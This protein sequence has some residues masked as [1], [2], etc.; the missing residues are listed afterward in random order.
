MFVWVM[1]FFL[2]AIVAVS[3]LYLVVAVGVT[4]L[5]LR[6]RLRRLEREGLPVQP[7]RF[8]MFLPWRMMF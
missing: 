4:A 6:A 5:A 3:G 1:L 2:L 8:A 7:V